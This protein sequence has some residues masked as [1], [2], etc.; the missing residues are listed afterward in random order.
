MRLAIITFVS[1]CAMSLIASPAP[2]HSRA[3]SSDNVFGAEAFPNKLNP[4]GIDVSSTLGDSYPEAHLTS[5]TNEPTPKPTAPRSLADDTPAG[6]GVVLNQENGRFYVRDLLPDSVAA[7]SNLIHTGDRILAVGEGEQASRSVV[8]RNLGDV[9]A[10]IRGEEGT[11]VRLTVAA[12]DHDDGAAREVLLTR[13]R[14]KEMSGLRLGGKPLSAGMQAPELSYRRLSDGRTASVAS[15]HAGKILVVEFWATWCG[16]CQ[17][18]MNDLQNLAATYAAQ[19]DKIDFLTISI[20]GDHKSENPIEKVAAHV[21]QNGWTRTI[22]GWCTFQQRKAWCVTAVPTTYII[23][24]DGK[25]VVPGPEQ[26]LG[27][28]IARLLANAS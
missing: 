8:G 7:A 14:L 20:D 27:D 12:P 26:E 11:R 23:G 16:P 4:S 18:T 2:P 24:R 25:I 6:V 10:M 5:E 17:Q 13:G 22:N 15:T 19:S 9:V 21:K 1:S 28:L 3:R